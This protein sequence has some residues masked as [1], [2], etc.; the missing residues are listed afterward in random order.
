[1]FGVIVLW[2]T[3]ISGYLLDGSQPA[4]LPLP[5]LPHPAMPC[6][7]TPCPAL[8]CP[9]NSNVCVCCFSEG[10]TKTAIASVEEGEHKRYVP[11]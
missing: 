4:C 9:H 7:A 5:A 6:P 1:M 3:T 2:L 11:Y 10:D 8:S